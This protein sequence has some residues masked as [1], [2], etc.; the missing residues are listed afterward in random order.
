MIH[1]KHEA[2]RFKYDTV[3]IKEVENEIMP[4]VKH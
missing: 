3:S 4:G 2:F 1:D